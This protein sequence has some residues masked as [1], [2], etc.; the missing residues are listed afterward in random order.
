MLD[1]QWGGRGERGGCQDKTVGFKNHHTNHLFVGLQ[2]AFGGAQLLSPQ[3]KSEEGTPPPSFPPDSH[4][5]AE[6][7]PGLSFSSVG[8]RARASGDL[9]SPARFLRNSTG[10][11]AAPPALPKGS[12]EACGQAATSWEA[13][14]K[15]SCRR[16]V[17]GRLPEAPDHRGRAR[18]AWSREVRGRTSR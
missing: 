3:N 8:G 7:R 5:K 4:C 13:R 11:G 9:A 6:P 17:P 2:S 14:A 16:G 12:S 1:G 18:L 15:T 10:I